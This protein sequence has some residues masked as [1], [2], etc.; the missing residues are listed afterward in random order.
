MLRPLRYS[1]ILQC[2]FSNVPTG[3]YDAYVWTY[4]DNNSI[5]ATLSIN[6]QVVLPSYNT[7]AAGHWDRLGPYRVIMTGGTMQFVWTCN[8]AGDAGFLSGI[9]L[10]QQGTPPASPTNVRIMGP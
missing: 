6:G 10:W 2:N 3:T 4:E 5:S 1:T 9:E 7:G 8:T